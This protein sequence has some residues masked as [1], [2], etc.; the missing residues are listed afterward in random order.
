MVA[1]ASAGANAGVVSTFG[2]L[3]AYQ[4]A[5]GAAA[6]TVEDFGW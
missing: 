4:T 3:G 1:L 6:E 2:T 5:I